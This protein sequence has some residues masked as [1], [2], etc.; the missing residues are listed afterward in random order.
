MVR[1]V[2]DERYYGKKDKRCKDTADYILPKRGNIP[3]ARKQVNKK[4]AQYVC[5]TADVMNPP[6]K[7]VS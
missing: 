7:S 1:Y 4:R 5:N 6:P 2:R 3:N